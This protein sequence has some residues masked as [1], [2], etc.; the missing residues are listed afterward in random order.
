MK[1]GALHYISIVSTF[2]VVFCSIFLALRYTIGLLPFLNG[3]P[4]FWDVRVSDIFFLL[5]TLLLINKYIKINSPYKEKE[6]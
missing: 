6:R 2:I 3:K 5:I 1:K 4:L